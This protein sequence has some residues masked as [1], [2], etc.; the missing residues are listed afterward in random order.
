MPNVLKSYKTL[1]KCNEILFTNK[2]LR[3]HKIK[4]TLP[5]KKMQIIHFEPLKE[6]KNVNILKFLFLAQLENDKNHKIIYTV[7][8]KGAGVTTPHDYQ[9]FSEFDCLR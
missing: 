4:Y 3:C 8:Y 9:I 2:S 6:R 7:R 5:Q 1:H